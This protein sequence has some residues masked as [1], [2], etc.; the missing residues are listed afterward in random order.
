MNDSLP[1]KQLHFLSLNNKVSVITIIIIID[2][3]KY[4]GVVRLAQWRERNWALPE[5][6]YLCR[7]LCL[8]R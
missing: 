1:L 3:K 4:A 5:S 7:K 8:W 6:C 2:K